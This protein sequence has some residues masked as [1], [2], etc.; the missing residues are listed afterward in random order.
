MK[1]PPPT[2]AA[3]LLF[4][5]IMHSPAWALD[6]HDTVLPDNGDNPIGV[7]I[8]QWGPQ[9]RVF[10]MQHNVD[11]SDQYA[12]LHE[13]EC[14]AAGGGLDY[15]E[16]ATLQYTEDIGPT[17]TGN[18]LLHPAMAI[19][20][21]GNELELNLTRVEDDY[22]LSCPDVQGSA[23][24]DL[25]S[26]EVKPD[27]SAGNR[28]V[29]EV[30][31]HA[32]VQQ[33]SECTDH[34]VTEVTFDANGKPHACYTNHTGTEERVQ[35]N[36]YDGTGQ[37]EWGDADTLALDT[38]PAGW[39]TA[40][41][42]P[43]F[44]MGTTGRLVALHKEAKQTGGSDNHT[45]EL[46]FPDGSTVDLDNANQVVKNFPNTSRNNGVLRVV[47][48]SGAGASAELIYA[49]CST[50]CKQASSWSDEVIT[51]THNDAK[52]VHHVVDQGLQREF[53]AFSYNSNPQ[54]VAQN[55]VAVGTRCLGAAAT[56]WA[57][58][59]VRT[60]SDPTYD[61]QLHYGR[62]GIVLDKTNDQVMVAFIEASN[63]NNS[64]KPAAGATTNA[65]WVRADYGGLASCL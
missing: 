31:V 61:Q 63:W 11:G 1:A 30:A 15:C 54:G 50:N 10:L 35:C 38:V 53:V 65:V 42:H 52:H 8:R 16:T 55:R 36:E 46:T 13:Y 59:D 5:G 18:H 56:A 20:K 32:A 4:V 26:Y 51:D 14:D 25:A 23:V 21:D 39:T 43:S 22:W 44:S 62:P 24:W 27:N 19:R 17:N 47:W 40:E 41:D 33:T 29:W 12:E 58:E 7:S 37:Y 64:L 3:T 34:G 2:L 6:W 9:G 60:P 49:E 57:F 45:I 28:I 48:E